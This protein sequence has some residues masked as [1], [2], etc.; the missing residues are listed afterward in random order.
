MSNLLGAVR[1]LR[2]ALENPKQDPSGYTLIPLTES[3]SDEI[4]RVFKKALEN[5]D[6]LPL[7]VEMKLR[8][9]ENVWGLLTYHPAYDE[10][11]GTRRGNLNTVREIEAALQG[12]ATPGVLPTSVAE[13]VEGA[14]AG[15]D[16]GGREQDEGDTV[17]ITPEEKQAEA[18][19]RLS[20]D[21]LEALRNLKAVHPEMRATGRDIA[22]EVGGDATEQSVKAPLA[23]LKRRNLVDS[24]TGRTG[25]SW[26]T[27][28]GL[29][30]INSLRP[31]D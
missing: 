31:K 1:K 12:P 30:L 13:Q 14:V 10:A 2:N 26:L 11:N 9:I 27:A 22:A 23:G 6:D 18:L 16:Q 29:A 7:G 20:Y 8:R 25:G 5:P 28:T 24:Q 19:S 15:R 4:T 3:E 21:I 17:G